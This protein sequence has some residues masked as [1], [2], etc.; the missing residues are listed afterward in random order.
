MTGAYL[1]GRQQIP[2]PAVRRF[3][4]LPSREVVAKGASEHGI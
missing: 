4:P 2:V 3:Y 1:T